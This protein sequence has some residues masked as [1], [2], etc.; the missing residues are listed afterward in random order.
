[1]CLILFSVNVSPETPLI[2]AANR[3]EFFDRPTQK[4]HFWTDTPNVLAGRDTVSSG[5]WLGMTKTGRFAAVTNVREPHIVVDSPLSRGDLT[6]DFLC[7]DAKPED[8]LSQVKRQGH[9]YPGFNLIVGLIEHGQVHL[10]YY[11]NRQ[12]GIHKLSPGTY[13]LSNHLLNSSWPKVDRGRDQLSALSNTT[14]HSKLRGLLENPRLANDADLPNTGV[15]YEREKMLS[16]AFIISPDYGTRCS[17]IL[18]VEHGLNDSTEHNTN[19]HFS[20]Q[21]YTPSHTGEPMLDGEDRHFR[22]DM[23]HAAMIA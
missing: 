19:I 2:L 9:R 17:S 13:G 11:G 5:T 18:T 12:D 8:Y 3:D 10:F 20:E 23:L 4:A 7:G 22:F 15:S 6:R 21:L 1:M 14:D 16:A